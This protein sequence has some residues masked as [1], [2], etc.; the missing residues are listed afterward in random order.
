[1]LPPGRPSRLSRDDRGSDRGSAN[2]KSQEEIKERDFTS[3]VTLAETLRA[4]SR[5][6]YLRV[7]ET[8]GNVWHN[9]KKVQTHLPIDSLL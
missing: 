2:E 8:Q 4:S 9:L 7:R 3:V 5:T 1:M 6:H